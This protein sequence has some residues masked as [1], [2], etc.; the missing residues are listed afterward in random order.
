VG[1]DDGAG[2][3]GLTPRETEVLALLQRRLTNAEIAEAL[4]LSVR[5]V[6]S[7][8]SALL[9]KLGAEDRRSLARQVPAVAVLG[10][11]GGRGTPDASRLPSPLT[12]FIGRAEERAALARAVREHR[13]VTATGPG[14]V[15][16]TRLALAVADDLGGEY[17]DG[18]AFVDLVKVTEPAMVV[19]AV[20]DAV[21]VQ[22]QAGAT[23][24]ETLVAVL[25]DRACLIVLDNCEHVV[26]AARACVE[27]VLSSCPSVRVLSTS[28][29]R[30]MLAFE[31]VFAVPGLSIDGD[32]V[33][34]FVAR[35][36]AAGGPAP[37]DPHDHEL[38]RAICRRVDGTAL[39][40]ELAAARAPS[41]GLAELDRALGASLQLLSVGRRSDDRH[42]SLWAAIDW[43]Y[44]LLDDDE[45]AVLRGVAVFAAAFDAEAA[46]AVTGHDLPGVQDILGRLVDWNLVT[47]R[48]GR[49]RASFRVL[50]TIRQYATELALGLE[51]LDTIRSAHHSWCALTLSQLLTR[52]GRDDEWCA[53]VDLVL[54]DA[55]A[56]L[57]WAADR[58]DRRADNIALAEA[59]AAVSFDRGLPAEAQRR[60]QEA[61]GWSASPLDARRD[62]R[63]AAGAA[64][65]R[66]AG[67]DAVDLLVQAAASA[68]AEGED[69][70]AA[71]DLALAAT[72]QR[73]ASGIMAAPVTPEGS[74][75]LLD[76][77]RQ[78]SRGGPRAEAA[79]AI[80]AGWAH[81]SVPSS[82]AAVRTALELAQSDR[83]PLLVDIALDLLIVVQ[84]DDYD[85]E[86]AMATVRERVAVLSHVPIDALSG[87]EHYDTHHMGCHLALAAG[88]LGT[89]RRHAVAVAALPFLREERHIGLS[90]HMEV[91]AIAGDFDAVLAAAELF[92]HDWE[93][94]GRPVA[95]NLAGG[96]YAAATVYGMVGNSAAHARW[97]AITRH[98]I[99]PSKP[100]LD[101]PVGWPPA[102]DALLA[103][104][105]DDPESAFDRLAADPGD[106]DAW[107]NPNTRLW[108]PWYTAT[109]AEASALTGHPGTSERLARAPG[110]VA[111]NDIART[112]IERAQALHDRE[113]HLL[114]ELAPRFTSLGCPY[115]ANRT[116]QL[117]RGPRT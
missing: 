12:P 23:H 111:G 22:E 77:A 97:V 51:E 98:L 4:Y 93:R 96:A 92:E 103:L 11:N 14:G 81:E 56:A 91:D 30:L 52:P 21:G 85:L 45:R 63:L 84:L 41:L 113:Y 62:I 100:G 66:N 15:G 104:H 39:A 105:L 13:L 74:E 9:R 18:A 116:L 49:T 27:R 35:L 90:R 34:L 80:A 112:V 20:A 24:D 99:P 2:V 107:S 110:Y 115:Q 114:G 43:S 57:G 94:G 70:L 3:P 1:P 101:A 61:A 76:R 50:E 33:A 17:R 60:Y 54:D 6:E 64:T 72:L 47:L 117:A 59:V 82:R 31:H 8:V 42:R 87:F 108:L 26:D 40:I 68:R 106:P 48:T 46:S 28:R 79:I 69:D 55:R 95:S 65:A 109:W 53:D 7:H 67:L 102:L 5:T 75:A 25:A 88:D 71:E 73:R 10:R 78:A 58:A 32:A 37:D 83:D 86:A 19:S 36:T 44:D 38:V 89:A 29:V 16:K